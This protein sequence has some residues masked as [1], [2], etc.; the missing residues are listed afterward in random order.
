MVLDSNVAVYWIWEEEGVTMQK[1]LVR[2]GWIVKARDMEHARLKV[3]R[4]NLKPAKDRDSVDHYQ[5]T[6]YREVID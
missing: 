4:K 2:F 3:K 6:K 1:Y 5:C